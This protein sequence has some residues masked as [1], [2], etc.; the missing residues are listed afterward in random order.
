MSDLLLRQV[1]VIDPGGPHNNDEIDILIRKGRIEKIGGRIPKND[2]REIR[3]PGLHVSI[4][5]IDLRA[6]FRDPSFHNLQSASV[7][8][9]GGLVADVIVAVGQESMSQA[10]HVAPLRSG[11]KYGATQFQDTVDHDGLTDAFE[12]TAMGAL[13]DAGNNPLGLDRCAQD[14]YAAQSHQRAAQHQTF[15]AEEIA[16]Y[17]VKTRRGETFI[18]HDDGIRADA[19]AELDPIDR[20]SS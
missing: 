9:E 20:C 12:H 2:V 3:S 19:T 18:E 5:W 10:P 16:P 8:A 4:G 13:T 14:T 15:L 1:K 7:L 17:T 11:T 6:H